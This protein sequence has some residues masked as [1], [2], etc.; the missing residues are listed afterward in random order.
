M[1]LI[2]NDWK[3]LLRNE[4]TQKSLFKT[5][6]C[7]NQGPRKTKDSH[8]LSNKEIHFT[9]QSNNNKYIKTFKGTQATYQKNLA[10]NSN[11]LFF[12]Q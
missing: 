4:A 10:K 8:I 2:W 11:T 9:L 7:I 6:Y 3:H 12:L 5:F 1:H